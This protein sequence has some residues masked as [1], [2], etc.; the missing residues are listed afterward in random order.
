[1]LAICHGGVL[2]L[3]NPQSGELIRAFRSGG[4]RANSFAWLKGGTGFLFNA[5][6]WFKIYD[7]NN[8]AP[9][10]E[11]ERVTRWG[12]LWCAVSPDGRLAADRGASAIRIYHVQDGRLLFTILSLRDGEYA[13]ISPDGHYR[14]SPGVEKEFAYVV[15]TDKGQETLTPEEFSTRYG[16][17]NDPGRVQAGIERLADDGPKAEARPLEPGEPAEK[18]SP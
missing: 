16:W 11:V 14:G 4:V 7:L 12:S 9:V 13:V 3:W 10:R 2:S 15:Q 6:I 17:K 5:N 1:M 18:P 8:P